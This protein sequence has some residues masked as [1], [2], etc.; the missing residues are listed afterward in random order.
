MTEEEK[1]KITYDNIFGAMWFMYEILIGSSS[2]IPFTMGNA[3]QN[4]I[5]KGLYIVST[6]VLLIHLLNMLIAIMGGTYSDR[7]EIANQIKVRDHL[8]FVIDNW[9][10]IDKVFKDKQQIKY[11]VT[12]FNASA[13]LEQ[14]EE[15]PTVEN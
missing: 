15:E 14:D 10:L 5:L 2:T 3:S 4:Y 6:F 8:A 12:A 13:D 7:S 9:N 11:I 1:E